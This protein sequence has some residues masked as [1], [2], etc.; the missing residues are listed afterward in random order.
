M[1]ARPQDEP[2]RLA[3]LVSVEL[4]RLREED[5]ARFRPTIDQALAERY[6]ERPR[7]RRDQCVVLSDRASRVLDEELGLKRRVLFRA[8][9]WASNGLWI[10]V[11]VIALVFMTALWLTK[12]LGA[13]AAGNV[14]IQGFMLFVAFETIMLIPHTTLTISAALTKP[15]KGHEPWVLSIQGLV[16]TFAAGATF[17]IRRLPDWILRR[18]TG[19]AAERRWLSAQVDEFI[20]N[21]NRQVALLAASLSNAFWFCLI[22][23]VLLTAWWNTTWERFNYRWETSFLLESEQVDVI[24][25]IGAPIAWLVTLPDEEAVHWLTHGENSVGPDRAAWE[26]LHQGEAGFPAAANRE[27]WDRLWAEELERRA[28]VEQ[29]YRAIWTK[30]LLGMLVV[31]GLIPR[32]ILG[33]LQFFL[34]WVFARDLWPN[35]ERPYYRD[36]IENI[37]QP[38]I[39]LEDSP[40]EPQSEPEP[41]APLPP[42]PAPVAVAP[43]PPPPKRE[44]TENWIVS[45]EV[46]TPSPGWPVALGFPAGHPHTDLGQVATRAE[47]RALLDRVQAEADAV[48]HLFLVA[49]V[50]ESPDNTFQD[51]LRDLSSAV[52]GANKI[53]VI[54]TEL[55]RL[56]R[57]EEGD[58]TSIGKRVDV[59]ISRCERSGIQAARVWQFDHTN[60]TAESLRQIK[61]RFEGTLGP[62]GNGQPT[63]R[64]VLAGRFLRAGEKITTSVASLKGDESSQ[65]LRERSKLLQQQLSELYREQVEQFLDRARQWTV[66]LGKNASATTQALRAQIP[67]ALD[68][69]NALGPL[70]AI[71]QSIKHLSSRWAFAGGG[72]GLML[73]AGGVLASLPALPLAVAPALVTAA[74]ASGAV[75]GTIGTLLGA[76]ASALS[77]GKAAELSADQLVRDPAAAEGFGRDDLARTSILWALVLELQGN[78]ADALADCLAEVT[79]S[80]GD[81]PLISAEEVS[82]AVHRIDAAL[83][84]YTTRIQHEGQRA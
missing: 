22:L 69:T 7:K 34:R 60:S 24:Q 70:A 68:P 75:T 17:L 2:V 8:I 36:T 53:V 3:D 29:D 49:D 9:G 54:L 57:Q 12:V 16:A 73:G 11:A 71:G 59:W 31:Y 58:P 76:R 43:S 20:S 62:T 6:P 82:A 40:E 55:D 63:S 44:P 19:R 30:Y 18:S 23:G 21:Q 38:P 27:G 56:R 10:A 67:S 66:D 83:R 65:E 35:V 15:G 72:L 79:E 61:R 84:A 39:G 14:S 32:T 48:A 1:T 33:L 47:R 41:P 74:L 37:Y 77:E 46:P 64:W 45:Y 28:S 78:S 81:E 51:Y 5:Q 13:D 80:A 25:T 52:G 26:D 50:T 42:E 4:M